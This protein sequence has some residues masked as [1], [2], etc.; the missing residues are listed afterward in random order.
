MKV[1]KC[2]ECREAASESAIPIY[3]ESDSDRSVYICMGCH[4]KFEVLWDRID[5]SRIKKV[6]EIL[7]EDDDFKYI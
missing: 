2:P 5:K 4:T 7:S 3:R 6:Q 1:V